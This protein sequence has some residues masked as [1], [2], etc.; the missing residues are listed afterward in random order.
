MPVPVLLVLAL[1][2]AFGAVMSAIY[3][4]FAL[5]LLPALPAFLGAIVGLWAWA[6]DYARAHVQ[7]S[8]DW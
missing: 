3:G 5:L 2:F 6:I 4:I 1:A 8:D 7:G